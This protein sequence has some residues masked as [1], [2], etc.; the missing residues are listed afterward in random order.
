ML[1]EIPQILHIGPLAIHSYGITFAGGV[2]AAY[3]V[4]RWAAVQRGISPEQFDDIAFWAVVVGFI[5]ARAYYVLTYPQYFAGNLLEVFKTWDG[6]LS[7][8]GGILGGIAVVYFRVRR[9]KVNF[10]NALDAI[11]IGVPLGQAIGRIGNYINHE[12]F[13]YPTNLPWK[14]FIPFIDRPVGYQQY[15]YFQPT[16]LYE[17]IAD[18]LI[19][20]ILL[21]WFRR[22][23]RS[24][25]TKKR[26]G[27]FFAVYLVLYGIARYIIE[28]MRLDSS[29]ILGTH[30][31]RFDQFIA[32]LLFLVGCGILYRSIT[33]EA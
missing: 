16:F 31:L 8:F 19:F 18:L 29:Y 1:P 25:K 11:V 26:Y 15:S 22:S 30:F 10:L 20:F 27:I 21:V 5:S 23:N 14:I 9:L 3:L 6:G 28:G 2:V 13:G 33:Y 7:I 12:A 17:M 24:E 4:G 32:I